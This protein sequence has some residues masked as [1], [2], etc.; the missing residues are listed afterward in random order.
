VDA[1]LVFV[2]FGMAAAF[3][4]V[5]LLGG[6]AR[7]METTASRVADVR[8][9]QR[10]RVSGTA[11]ELDQTLTSP[12]GGQRCIAYRL[13]VDEPGKEPVLEHCACA[14]FLLID[15]DISVVVEGPFRPLLHAA[16]EWEFGNDV[17]MKLAET[18]RRVRLDSGDRAAEIDLDETYSRNYRYFEALL[19]PGDQVTVEGFAS[20]EVDPAGLRAS[21]REPPM[22]HALAGSPDQPALIS[23]PWPV[24]AKRGA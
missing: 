4:T 18:I 7:V 11:G 23:L 6:G 20:G 17:Q 15:G 22:R 13:M 1:S 12:I 24:T 16:Y 8:R 14:R 21:L 9:G 5:R 2:V 3:V 19:R 10:L